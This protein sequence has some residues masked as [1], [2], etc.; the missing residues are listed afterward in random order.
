MMISGSKRS[1]DRGQHPYPGDF[2][3]EFAGY[4]AFILSKFFR[5][6][7]LYQICAKQF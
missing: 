3:P 5:I 6:E 7:V 4:A 1:I 2:N